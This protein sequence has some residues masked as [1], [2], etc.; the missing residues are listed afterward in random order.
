MNLKL[1][2]K[3]NP[4]SKTIPGESRLKGTR[5]EWS[6]GGRVSQRG[7]SAGPKAEGPEARVAFVLPWLLPDQLPPLPLLSLL[8]A[9]W[10]RYCVCN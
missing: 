1:E 10:C 4:N 8:E 9:R 6:P 3:N 5:M 2:E 7:F